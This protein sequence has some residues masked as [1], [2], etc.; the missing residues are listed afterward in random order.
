MSGN[1]FEWCFDWHP[2]YVGSRVT[3]GGSWRYY[4]VDLLVGSLYCLGPYG[5]GSYFGFRFVRTITYAIGDIGPGGGIVFYITN[6]GLNGLEAAPPLWNGGSADPGSAWSN[7]E[8]SAVGVSAQGTAIGTGLA[9][10]NAIIAQSGHTASAAKLCRDY[11]GGGKT[12]WFLPSK[13][14]LN[15]L[16][17]QQAV[18]GGFRQTYYWSSSEINFEYAWAQISYDG[19]QYGINKYVTLYVRAVRAF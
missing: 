9:N 16:Y 19:D 14:E 10:S 12:D 17:L 7:I 5:E 2:S 18:V 13:D 1:V 8:T 6:G 11:T 15:Q 4:D 3:R